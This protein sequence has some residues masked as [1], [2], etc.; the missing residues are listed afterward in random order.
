LW[1]RAPRS[2]GTKN[3]PAGIWEKRSGRTARPV[4]TAAWNEH[5]SLPSTT[6]YQRGPRTSIQAIGKE[7]FERR[8][9]VDLEAA[10][11]EIQPAV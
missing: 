2:T 4:R 5:A 3:R 10:I 6:F 9:G 1:T 11:V 8:F 7:E